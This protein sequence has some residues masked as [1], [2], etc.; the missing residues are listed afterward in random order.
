[1]TRMT[2]EIEELYLRRDRL[3]AALEIIAGMASTSDT[4]SEI[5]KFAEEVLNED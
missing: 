5:S 2:N 3:E 1:M 4:Y